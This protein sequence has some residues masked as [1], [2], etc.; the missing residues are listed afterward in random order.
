M[1]VRTEFHP[2]IATVREARNPSRPEA[3]PALAGSR[4][5]ARHAGPVLLAIVWMLALGFFVLAIAVPAAVMRRTAE[6]S[7]VVIAERGPW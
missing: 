2:S 6:A 7:Q 1:T 4:A 3:F 5:R